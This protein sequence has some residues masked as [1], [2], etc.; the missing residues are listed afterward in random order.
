[1]NQQ[2]NDNNQK[3]SSNIKL[4]SSKKNKKNMKNSSRKKANN[5]NKVKNIISSRKEKNKIKLIYNDFELNSFDYKNALLHDKRTCIQYYLSLIKTKNLILFSFCPA[6]DYNSQ[7]I[8]LY[9][10]SL[11]FSIYYAINFAFFNDNMLHKIYELGGKYDFIYFIPK[12]TI[13]FVISYV[14]STTIKYIF[15]SER[16]ISRVRNQVILSMAY[17]TSSKEERNLVIKYTIFFILGIIFLVFFWMLLSSF[18]AVYQN[19]QIFIFENTLISFAMS[20]CYQF[21]INIFPCIFRIS[22]LNSESKNNEGMYKIS[23]FLQ[24]L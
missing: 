20:L 10:F 11:S 14:I 15:V 7:I 5:V 19:T 16:N 12:I 17:E 4:A 13:S 24:I 18:S 8:K 6:K 22:S 23:K 3:L 1:M 2:N 9:I 21:F